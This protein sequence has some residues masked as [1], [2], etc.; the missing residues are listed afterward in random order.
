MEGFGKIRVTA[1][2]IQSEAFGSDIQQI[3]F[4]NN[5]DELILVAQ[6]DDPINFTDQ[7]NSD[8]F[9]LDLQIGAE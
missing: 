9:Q 1:D 8:K 6:L 3:G 7:F 2:L 5:S 4:F